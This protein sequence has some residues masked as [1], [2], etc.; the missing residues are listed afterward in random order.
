MADAD[1][2][3][4]GLFSAKDKQVDA[5]L[6]A[7]EASVE[8]LGGRVVGRQI[9]RRGVSRGGAERM[10]LPLSRRTL[11]S[12][13]KAREVGDACRSAAVALAVFVNPLTEHQRNVLSEL[14]GCPVV[15]GDDLIKEFA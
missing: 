5:K 10:T 13:G 8:A 3:L 12:S 1:V 14:F 7:L 15:G 4:V 9:Q 11:L 2:M 6:A